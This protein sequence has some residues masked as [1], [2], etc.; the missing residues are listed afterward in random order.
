VYGARKLWRQL[1]REGIGVARCTVERLLGE[2]GLQGVVRGKPK[3]TTV[4]DPQAER[5]A[6]LV[7][8]DVTAQRPNQLWVADLT[9]VRSWSGFCYAAFIVDADSRLLV[10]WQLAGHLRTDLAPDALE[11]AIWRRQAQLD[12]LVHH[13]DRGGQYLSIRD[14]DRLAEAGAVTSVGSRGDS[15]DNALAESTIGLSKTELIRR[16]GPGAAWTTWSWP[17][18]S[19]STGTTTAGC[20]APSTTSRRS[21]TR[22]PTLPAIL[23]SP[24]PWKALP[25][26][27]A[28]KKPGAVHPLDG[29]VVGAVADAVQ[30]QQTGM[31]LEPPLDDLGAVDGDVVA[32]HRHHWRLWVEGQKVFAEGGKGGA[33]GLAGHLIQEATRGKVDGAEDGAAPVGAWGHDLLALPPEDPGGPHPRQQVDVGLVLG[34]QHRTRGQVAD[35]LVEVGEDLVAVGVA[36]C[37]QAGPPPAGDL[38]HTAVQGPQADSGAAQLLPQPA[39]GPGLGL[40]EQPVDAPGQPG[41]AQSWTAAA[42]PVAQPAGA[43]LVVAV[44]PAAHGGGVAAEQPG[45][46]ARGPAVLGEQDHHQAAADAVGGRA[47]GPAGRRGSRLG[48]RGWRTRWGDAYFRRPGRVGGAVEGFSD[49]RGSCTSVHLQPG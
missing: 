39:D 34:Q 1:H 14:T 40:V 10:G 45:D 26:R 33:D 3:R 44:D 35:V 2:L 20:T 29:V 16:R 48:R 7:C 24:L 27:P 5:P 32:D 36:A 19:G 6:D 49:P 37:D 12:G 43:V 15:F 9:S 22:P 11:M 46:L 28:S 42:G 21:S 30:H 8:R 47:A 23:T 41:A 18:W 25:H 38:A 17:P 31:S 4:G 13:S